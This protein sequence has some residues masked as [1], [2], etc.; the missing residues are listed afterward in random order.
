M[1]LLGRWGGGMR[2]MRDEERKRKKA[3]LE[4]VG[5]ERRAG[6]DGA[7]DEEERGGIHN[8]GIAGA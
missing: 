5:A 6:L 2:R 1:L 3:R 4:G 8:E 7:V